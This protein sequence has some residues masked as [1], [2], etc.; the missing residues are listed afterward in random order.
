LTFSQKV[1]YLRTEN[2]KGFKMN[3]I[4]TIPEHIIEPEPMRGAVAGM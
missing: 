3:K 1:V 2:N 4:V